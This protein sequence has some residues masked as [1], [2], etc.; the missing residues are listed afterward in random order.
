LKDGRVY[1]SINGCNTECIFHVPSSFAKAIDEEGM[2]QEGNG[3]E[4]DATYFLIAKYEAGE[5]EIKAWH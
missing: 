5:R 1:T 3:P 2:A 4:M